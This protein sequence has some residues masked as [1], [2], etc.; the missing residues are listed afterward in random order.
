MTS[1]ICAVLKLNYA[2]IPLDSYHHYNTVPYCD[3]LNMAF[4]ANAR[5]VLVMEQSNTGIWHTHAL[6]ASLQRSDNCARTLRNAGKTL[7]EHSTYD[8]RPEILKASACKSGR[9][10]MCYMLKNPHAIVTTL[11]ADANVCFN[12]LRH[13][14]ELP[15]KQK[16]LQKQEAQEKQLEL[17]QKL[18]Q[19][20]NPET[21]NEFTTWCL[22]H[23]MNA[24]KPLTIEDLCRIDSNGMRKF[25]HRPNL[26]KIINQCA[27]Y[28]TATTS[29]WN[30]RTL[31]RTAPS[32]PHA[33]RSIHNYLLF[34]GIDPEDFD[35]IFFKWLWMLDNKRNTLV[36]QGPSNTG[37]SAFI[38]NFIAA[39]GNSVGYICNGTFPWQGLTS[40]CTLGVWE[41]PLLSTCE[42]EKAKQILGGEKTSVAVKFSPPQ[43]IDRIPIVITTNHDLW[44]HCTNEQETLS[45]RIF[46]F[47]CTNKIVLDSRGVATSK[48]SSDT[49]CYCGCSGRIG[50]R[51]NSSNIS[52]PRC[53]SESGAEPT[54][55]NS[56]SSDSD[57][58]SGSSSLLS[59]RCSNTSPTRQVGWSHYRITGGS[60][61]RTTIS[62]TDS[63]RYNSCSSTTAEHNYGSS[64]TDRSSDT[65]NRVSTLGGQCSEFVDGNGIGRRCI[66]VN[67]G[68]YGALS[69]LGGRLVGRPRSPD[70]T[71]SA[72]GGF[73][74]I[75]EVRPLVDDCFFGNPRASP[76]QRESEVDRETHT[77]LTVPT[78][79]EWKAYCQY[80]LYNH[81]DQEDI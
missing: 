55:R 33:H 40:N 35:F 13:K 32:D 73:E 29:N 75:D 8:C 78:A 4:G 72:G 64:Y 66:N 57:S 60:I 27:I 62:S 20:A 24:Q 80:L 16:S 10:M 50:N 23:M 65:D 53:G 19:N 44:R 34:Q 56:T 46:H 63:T 7:A 11:N 28:Y 79:E 18:P 14:L 6:I 2:K 58:S 69:G 38:K 61:T 51:E 76:I 43:P 54:R 25:L 52:S 1:W 49:R 48:R 3:W 37:K 47:Y 5:W 71:G 30:P 59:G 17:R 74:E 36:L 77:T 42:A 68:T 31:T 15:Y 70:S 12:I 41:E 81:G 67:I 21:G 45:N 26:S 22:M 39:H 9:G